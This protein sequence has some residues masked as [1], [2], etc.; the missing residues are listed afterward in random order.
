M[1]SL[2]SAV[3]T[4][5][6]LVS[7]ASIREFCQVANGMGLQGEALLRHHNLDQ[8]LIKL[9]NALVRYDH[10]AELLAD[11]AKNSLCAHFGLLLGDALQPELIDLVLVAAQAENMHAA[12]ESLIEY[13]DLFG[14]GVD[15][16]LHISDGLASLKYFPLSCH[17]CN[18]R[19]FYDLSAQALLK[20][21]RYLAGVDIP[22]VSVAMP[23]SE[24][25]DSDIYQSILGVPCQFEQDAVAVIFETEYLGHTNPVNLRLR[26]IVLE[27]ADAELAQRQDSWLQKVSCLI[28]G[29]L[30]A[31]RCGIE[32][33]AEILGIHRRTLHNKLLAEGCSFNELLQ[34]QRAERSCYYLSQTDLS[35]QEIAQSVGY[36][37]SANFCNA[38]KRWFGKTPR[39]WRETK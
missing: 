28:N 3:T 6:P 14:Q 12:I 18:M 10:L 1:N 25:K 16:Q 27:Y 30:P 33:V 11:A 15:I 19:P 17:H 4:D 39:Q 24:P 20:I 23:G 21:V 2:N 22:I 13:R 9:P 32:N 34:R 26:D 31:G 37:E 36:T 29:L 8:N 38:F 35:L 7:T 5:Y